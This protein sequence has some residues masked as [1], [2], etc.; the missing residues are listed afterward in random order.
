MPVP[1]VV[2]EQFG[3]AKVLG[4]TAIGALLPGT[5]FLSAG[6]RMRLYQAAYGLTELRLYAGVFIAWL[7]VIP[8]PANDRNTM[9]DSQLKLPMM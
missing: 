9:P 2:D 7:A 1:H 4:L 5:A 3:F 6:Y 8:S